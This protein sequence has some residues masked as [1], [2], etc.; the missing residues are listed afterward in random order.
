MPLTPLQQRI[1]SVIARHRD[2]E[3][4]VAG[5]TVIQRA[6]IRRSRD[7]DIFHD[8]EQRLRLAAEVDVL[9]LRAT[10]FEVS[11]EL[12][13][14]TFV[15]AIIGAEGERTKLEWVVDSEFRFFPAVPDKE[16]GFVLHPFDLATNKILA[17][18]SRF[19]VRDAL[20]LLWVDEHVQA[21]GAIAW[22]TVE[23]DP[24]WMPEGVLS[25]LRWR[26]RYQ[27]YQLAEEDLLV[28]ITAAELNNQLRAK[29]DKAEQL[30]ARLPRTL[31]YGCLL[32]ADGSLAQP[33]PDRP[34]TLADL[35]VHHGSRKGAWPSSPEIGSVMLRERR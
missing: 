7:I 23:K 18:A 9:A 13:S 3:S 27:D 28:T 29:I 8:G 34:E 32:R 16:F 1:L 22:A 35:V 26:A 30:I 21:L 14:A 4:F 17:A 2:A 6:G 25:N 24:G 12:D 15:R 5:G 20:D 10:G 11:V 33:D 31:E 19:E